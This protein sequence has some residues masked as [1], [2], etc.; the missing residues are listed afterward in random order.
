MQRD[1][2]SLLPEVATRQLMTLT[3]I[4]KTSTDVTI[5]SKEMEKREMNAVRKV[6]KSWEE[7][8]LHSISWRWMDWLWTHCGKHYQRS[9]RIPQFAHAEVHQPVS[10]ASL[11]LRAY[12]L[13]TTEDCSVQNHEQQVKCQKIN[14]PWEKCWT[15]NSLEMYKYPG[16]PPVPW[17]NSKVLLCSPRFSPWN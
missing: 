5:W 13:K 14:N 4:Q 1:F 9:S 10:S 12:F 15:N 17:D 2:E 11:C 3:I 8:L 16:S 6:Y 7:K